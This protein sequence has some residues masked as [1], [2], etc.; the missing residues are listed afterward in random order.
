MLATVDEK[1]RAPALAKGLDILELLASE[2]SG[3]TQIEISATLG[4][5]TS[6]IFRM[7]VVLRQRG[8]VDLDEESGRY[9]LST[10]LF[11]ISHR[12]PPIRRLSAIA[13]EEMQRLAERINQSLHLAILRAGHILI[14]AQVD[15]PD[16]YLVSVRLGAKIPLFETASGRVLSAWLDK[17]ALEKTIAAAVAT[18]G[19]RSTATFRSS[20]KGVRKAGYC[21][22][23]S[24]T[25]EGV[26]NIAAPISDHSG[27]VIAALTIPYVQRL[28]AKSAASPSDARGQLLQVTRR[29]SKQLGAGIND[30]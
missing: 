20:L 3:K 4:R 2:T 25:L 26:R 14:I 6:E 8:Y 27:N 7:L 28:T 21:E 23:Q 19:D 22:A 5:T 29:M 12:Y 10:K 1:Y 18:S 30:Q 9:S 13:G 11:E 15:C 17:Q 16:D 24:L